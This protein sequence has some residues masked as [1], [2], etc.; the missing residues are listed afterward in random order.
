MSDMPMARAALVALIIAAVISV[1]YTLRKID[2]SIPFTASHY[3]V[4]I[5]F[6]NGA[7]LDGSDHPLATVAGTVQGRVVDV[8]LVDG[9]AV[10]TLELETDV[11]GKVFKDATAVLRPIGAIPVLSVNVDP[12]DP[13]QGALPD[14]GTITAE[15]TQ[16]YVASDQVLSVLDADTRAYIQVLIG[17]SDVALDGRGGDLERMIR[18]LAPMTAATKRVAEAEADRREL[19]VDLV[20]DLETIST[21]LAARRDQ[22][23]R[24]V[25]SG[26]QV[27]NVT[28][29]RS[30]ELAQVMRELPET[31]ESAQETLRRVRALAGPLSEAMDGALPAL[32]ELPEG[33][34][35]LR[36]LTPDAKDLLA[37]VEELEAI[38]K[39]E[40]PK[41]R[42]FA[43]KLGTA[44]VEGRPSVE[45]AAR[46]VDTLSNYSDGVAQLGDLVSGAVSTNDV[47][48]AMARAIISAVEPAKP[49]N[50]G[51]DRL[52]EGTST[53]RARAA[54]SAK[55]TKQQQ[56]EMHEGLAE[57]LDA[58]C[59]TDRVACIL[60][61][62]TPGLPGNEN[63]LP[64]DQG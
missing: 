38:G 45:A 13:A 23:A 17:Q 40:L 31:V 64:E 22:L 16:T 21:T 30:P 28:A 14:G 34:R 37:D 18:Q 11:E 24:V 19:I 8:E 32:D 54:S 15:K 2:V 53:T 46:T 52:P 10:A 20:G 55:S 51:F 42:D 7:G 9:K 39:T 33:L 27:L 5:E 47:N 35:E 44:A 48:G 61:A 36:R 26:S 63:L 43:S 25:D 29:A 56:Q 12:G 41:I 50:F 1:G 4:K 49:E 6:E 58:R 59:A 62:V 60:R 3:V 57:L